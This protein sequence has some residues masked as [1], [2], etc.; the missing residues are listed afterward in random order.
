MGDIELIGSDFD[1]LTVTMHTELPFNSAT[2][3]ELSSSTHGHVITFDRMDLCKKCDYLRLLTA[4]SQIY[5]DMKVN[6]K[7]W[8]EQ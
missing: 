3:V 7:F 8:L 4:K 5:L 2:A 1:C 6:K